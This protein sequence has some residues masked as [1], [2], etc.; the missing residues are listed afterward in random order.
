LI[1]DILHDVFF[2][3]AV[4]FV[5]HIVESEG[6]DHGHQ[7]QIFLVF[8]HLSEE[9]LEVLRAA[10]QKAHLEFQNFFGAVGIYRFLGDDRLSR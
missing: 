8:V 7:L 5:D 6:K 3:Q 4:L 1:G 2:F 9:F 10:A